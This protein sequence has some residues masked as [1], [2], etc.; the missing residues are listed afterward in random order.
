LQYLGTPEGD[1]SVTWALGIPPNLPVERIYFAHNTVHGELANDESLF[2]GIRDII[3][4]GNTT[5]L[6]KNKPSIHT[7]RTLIE[8]DGY[9]NLQVINAEPVS[10]RSDEALKILQGKRVKATPAKL[11]EDYLEVISKMMASS[12]PKLQ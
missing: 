4:Q 1:G 12:M 8:S 6:E 2:T 9:K 7:D 11:T 3:V 10:N 5:H